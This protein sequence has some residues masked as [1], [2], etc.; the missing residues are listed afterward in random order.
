MDEAIRP[1]P[2]RSARAVPAI[3]G[4]VAILATGAFAVWPSL[5]G[6]PGRNGLVAAQGQAAATPRWNGAL[7]PTSASS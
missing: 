2:S 7:R 5:G 3:A 6:G 4:C 1:F